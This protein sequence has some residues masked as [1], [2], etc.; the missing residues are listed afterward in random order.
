LRCPGRETGIRREIKIQP[1][2]L[3]EADHGCVVF[4][5]QPFGKFPGKSPRPTMVGQARYFQK[6][7]V[8]TLGDRAFPID[9]IDVDFMTP[10]PAGLG[11]AQEI[12][13]QPAE[14]EISEETEGQSHRAAPGLRRRQSA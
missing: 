3:I 8:E 4:N 6:M 12:P 9:G 14:G 5:G 1:R 13:L 11:D 2:Q 7:Q 10:F